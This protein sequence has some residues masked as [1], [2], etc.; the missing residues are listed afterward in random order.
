MTQREK[1]PR[2]ASSKYC[3][4]YSDQR[5]DCNAR[6]VWVG[7]KDVC[8][9]VEDAGDCRF[10]SFDLSL[11]R[12]LCGT[13]SCIDRHG[14]CM[15]TVENLPCCLSFQDGR[16]ADMTTVCYERGLEGGCEFEPVVDKEEQAGLKAT[17]EVG[18]RSEAGNE[19]GGKGEGERSAAGCNFAAAAGGL[20][21]L[22]TSRSRR[23]VRG[24]EHS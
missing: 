3:P 19:A 11:R 7:E 6:M 4:S 17:E 15:C 18:V 12:I 16:V 8:K 2:N 14:I 20:I 9:L 10:R 23:R 5:C 1:I 21:L 24:M 13:R 22:L